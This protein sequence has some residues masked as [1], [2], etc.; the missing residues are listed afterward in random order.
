MA[1]VLEIAAETRAAEIIATAQRIGLR[2][3]D[4]A[5]QNF[6]D[7]RKGFDSFQ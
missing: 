3:P 4:T 2:M 6:A 1:E 7:E 5:A